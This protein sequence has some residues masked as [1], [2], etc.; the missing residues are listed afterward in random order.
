MPNTGG[1]DYHYF[2]Y[3][4]LEFLLTFGDCEYSEARRFIDSL[5]SHAIESLFNAIISTIWTNNCYSVNT[6][7]ITSYLI[8]QQS[9]QDFIN[10]VAK[11]CTFFGIC[12]FNTI[13][14]AY[15]TFRPNPYL[16]VKKVRWEIELDFGS[17]N[18]F[19]IN[20]DPNKTD[21]PHD[22]NSNNSDNSSPNNQKQSRLSTLN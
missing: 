21:K 15:V 19:H 13:C 4:N 3:N 5:S 12:N 17:A 9:T 10:I 20:Y 6:A 7:T 2:S 16:Q 14:L 1:H 18:E 8:G 22:P 11:D